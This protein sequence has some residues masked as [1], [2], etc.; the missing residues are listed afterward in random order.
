MLLEVGGAGFL[1]GLALVHPS[2]LVLW[3]LSAGPID[4]SASDAK[5]RL[6][7]GTPDIPLRVSHLTTRDCSIAGGWARTVDAS[8]FGIAIYDIL[9]K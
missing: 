5:R 2:F 8:T 4:R 3:S 7:V 1:L 9:F 6:T